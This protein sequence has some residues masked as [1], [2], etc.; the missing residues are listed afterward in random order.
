MEGRSLARWLLQAPPV[1]SRPLVRE[2]STLRVA[3]TAKQ[4]PRK[5][6]IPEQVPTPSP[7]SRRRPKPANAEFGGNLDSD[8]HFAPPIRHAED[9]DGDFTRMMLA[10]RPGNNR[11]AVSAGNMKGPM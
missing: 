11:R 1:R 3:P 10:A 7:K 8:M 6:A 5:P 4:L 9:Y 2:R